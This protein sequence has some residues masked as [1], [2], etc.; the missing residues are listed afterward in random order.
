MSPRMPRAVL[1]LADLSRTSVSSLM[2]APN[3]H[4]HRLLLD[5]QGSPILKPSWSAHPSLMREGISSLIQMR[6]SREGPKFG[7][8]EELELESSSAPQAPPSLP[9]ALSNRWCIRGI[10]WIYQDDVQ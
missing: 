2:W 8:G 3:D 5:S 1:R 6:S 7:S 9:D 4:K 10:R